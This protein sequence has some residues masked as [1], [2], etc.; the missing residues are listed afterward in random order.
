MENRRFPYSP[1]VEREPMRFPGG[2]QIAIWV[3]PNIE[4]FHI[5]KPAMSL[6][7]PTAHLVPDVLN[8]SWRDFGARVG[9]W[10]MMEVMQRHDVRGTVALNSEVCDHYPQI[11]AAAKVLNWDFMGHGQTN[12]IHLYDLAED[13]ERRIICDTLDKIGEHVGVRPKGW[14]SPNLTESPHTPDLLAQEGVEYV[15]DW[16]NDEQP[17]FMNVQTGSLVALPYSAEINDITVFMGYNETGEDFYQRIVDQYEVLHHDGAKTG[18]VMAISLHPFLIGQGFRAKYLDKA[19][20]YLRLQD[21]IWWA[22]GAE[23]NDWFR[24]NA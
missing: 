13:E 24:A 23:L 4:H 20:A 17:Y 8:Y 9:V 10:R 1:I 19:L 5:D 12:S 15:A 7:P 21:G 2:A 14:L 3:T 11:V 18:R 6:A 22:T 16:V